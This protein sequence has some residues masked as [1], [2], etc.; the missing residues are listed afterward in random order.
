MEKHG[1]PERYDTCDECD[2][3]EN[4]VV[5]RVDDKDVCLDDCAEDEQEKIAS[6]YGIPEGNK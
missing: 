5:V 3:D 4:K 1:T 6:E 2:D